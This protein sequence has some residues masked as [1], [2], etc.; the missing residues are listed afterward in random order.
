VY[1]ECCGF[2]YY[3]NFPTPCRYVCCSGTPWLL[4]FADVFIGGLFVMRDYN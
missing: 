4:E 2:E 1:G 3:W